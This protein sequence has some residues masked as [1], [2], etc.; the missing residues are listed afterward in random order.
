MPS[1]HNKRNQHTARFDTPW[2]RLPWTG[3]IAISTWMLAVWGMS[4]MITKAPTRLKQVSPVD[5]QIIDWPTPPKPSSSAVQ[6]SPPSMQPS[7]KRMAPASSATTVSTAATITQPSFISEAKSQQPSEAPTQSIQNA[8]GTLLS[9]SAPASTSRP[10]IAVRVEADSIVGRPMPLNIHN[11]EN[12]FDSGAGQGL[13]LGGLMQE[14]SDERD[15]TTEPTIKQIDH[16]GPGFPFFTTP[17]R[18]WCYDA[19]PT[20]PWENGTCPPRFDKAIAAYERQD[21]AAAFAQLKP[22]ALLEYPPAQS[23]LGIMY[24]KGEGVPQDDQEAVYWYKKAAKEGE[25]KGLYNLALMYSDGR[26]VPKD[27]KKAAELYR[28]AAYF[29]FPDAQYNLGV[30]YALG[31]GVPKDDKMAAYWY[32]KAADRGHVHAQYNLGYMYEEGI[33]LPRKPKEAVYWYCKAASRADEQGRD[34]L[35]RMVHHEVGVPKNQELAYFCWLLTINRRTAESR[36]KEYDIVTNGLSKTERAKAEAAA[37][38]R[39][40]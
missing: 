15:L 38:I 5:V 20:Q 6:A 3:L 33:S 28:R 29:G 23:S 7:Q 10:G 12:P 24:A 39:G 26:G 34:S 32:R 11:E 2:Q 21:Y 30:L 36:S 14:F 16:P 25:P 31:S 37:R 40:Y 9:D 19:H 17:P 1:Q 35:I 27:D 13:S 22:L 4:I 18:P 8:E